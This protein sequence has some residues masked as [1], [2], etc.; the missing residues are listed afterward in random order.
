MEVR[1][2]GARDADLAHTLVARFK[3]SAP[4]VG[5]M[6]GWLDDER[7]VLMVALD[8]GDAIGWVYGYE[9]PRIDGPRP[10][11]L[12]YEIDVMEQARG[13]GVGRALLD[14]FLDA[15]PGPVWLVTN[16]SN[17][18]AMRLYRSAGGQR[19]FPDD[20]MFRFKID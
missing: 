7:C 4:G 1:R 17:E 10:M 5:H 18:P 15:V 11:Y 2:L 14:A 6:R 16:S 3:Q 9:L 13:R 20:V 8:R 19:V 12:L